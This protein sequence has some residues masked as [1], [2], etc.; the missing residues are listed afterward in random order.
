MVKIKYNSIKQGRKE[1]EREQNYLGMEIV[2]EYYQ[3]NKKEIFKQA[4][5][6]GQDKF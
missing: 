5:Q 6:I 1:S 3:Q 2:Q 4:I